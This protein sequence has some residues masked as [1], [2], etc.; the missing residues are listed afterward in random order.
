[1]SKK[2]QPRIWVGKNYIKNNIFF[3]VHIKFT[4]FHQQALV[5]YY[6]TNIIFHLTAGLF[7]IIKI[8]FT[9]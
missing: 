8:L 5:N 9:K 1:M 7:V 2:A 3:S 6:F 4:K